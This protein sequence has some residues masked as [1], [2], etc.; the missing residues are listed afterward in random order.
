MFNFEMALRK[1]GDKYEI[2]LTPVLI[3]AIFTQSAY[4][5]EWLTAIFESPTVTERSGYKNRKKK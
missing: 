5:D 3:Y 2:L 4:T 1:R